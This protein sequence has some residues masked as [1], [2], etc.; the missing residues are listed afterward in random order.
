[1]SEDEQARRLRLVRAVYQTIVKSTMMFSANT[2]PQMSS[3]GRH[4]IS[5]HSKRISRV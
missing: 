3:S 5:L 4:R 1:M 2:P